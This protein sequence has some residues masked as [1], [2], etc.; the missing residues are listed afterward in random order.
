M[1]KTN[2]EKMQGLAA[3]ERLPKEHKAQVLQTISTAMLFGNIAELF[4]RDY[5]KAQGSILLDQKSDEKAQ[6]Q[7]DDFERT[8][9][10]E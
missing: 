5:A 3:D 4:T 2:K 7:K 8:D 6:D 10:E 1:A 9:E